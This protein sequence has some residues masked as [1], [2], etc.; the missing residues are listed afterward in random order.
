MARYPLSFAERNRVLIALGGIAA[1]VLVFFLTFNAASLPVIGNGDTYTAEFAESGGLRAGNEVRVAGVKVGEVTDV[2]LEKDTVVVSFQIKGV[3]L[4]DQTTA[5]VKVR[6]LLGRKYLALVPQGSDDLDGRIPLERTT[7]PY[8]VNA[9]FSDLSDE[10]TEIDTAKL[11]K[12]LDVLAAAFEETPESVREMVSG[13]SA[14]SRTISSRDE[15]LASLLS[16]TSSVTGTLAER[17]DEFAKI[18]QDGAD[19]FAE[20]ANRREAVHDMLT[21]TAALGTQL[22]GLVADNEKTLAPALAKLDKV[23]AILQRNQ[24]NLEEALLKLGPYYRVLSSATGNGHWI[25]SYLCGLFDDQHAPLLENDV[26][27]NC[28]PQKGGGR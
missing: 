26:L 12:S 6:T 13:L 17:N 22:R 24:G 11:E 3:H 16:S 28:K 9:A 4:G 27:R 7:T 19:L 21:G 25:D 23:S 1:M 14:L 20:L 15:E 18:M 5:S 10:I 2:R 8:D